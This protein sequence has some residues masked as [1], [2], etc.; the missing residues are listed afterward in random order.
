MAPYNLQGRCCS[1]PYCCGNTSNTNRCAYL[2]LVQKE[3]AYRSL[4]P[5]L[6]LDPMAPGEWRRN[7]IIWSSA[8]VP[9]VLT[10]LYFG[11]LLHVVEVDRNRVWASRTLELFFLAKPFR[12][13]LTRT[14]P[15]RIV[16]GTK[17]RDIKEREG[18]LLMLEE[19]RGSLAAKG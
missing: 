12:E 13:S 7:W 3:R 10:S 2:V 18:N 11:L 17:C 5:H 1:Y 8:S 19:L 9:G 14:L 16:G 4:Q 6:R 15:V